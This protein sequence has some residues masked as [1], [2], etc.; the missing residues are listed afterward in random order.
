MCEASAATSIPKYAYIFAGLTLSVD[1]VPLR[2]LPMQI[3]KSS[4]SILPSHQ[5]SN[6]RGEY[7]GVTEKCKG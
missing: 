7:E 2:S 6:E 4:V 3:R 5:F 1:R